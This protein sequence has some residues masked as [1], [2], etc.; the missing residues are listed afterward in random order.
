V[1]SERI[2]LMRYPRPDGAKCQ[3][4]RRGVKHSLHGAA[5]LALTMSVA[6]PA[7]RAQST[8][9]SAAAQALF[10]Q[11]R[12]LMAEGRHSEACPKLEES[13]RL[14]PGSG[15][16]LN[17]ARCYEQAG[18]LASAWIRYLEAASAAEATGNAARVREARQRA[19][20]VRPRLPQLV[21]TV[22]PED[23]ATAGLRVTRDDE[24]VGAAQWGSPIPIDPGE[25][26]IIASAPGRVRWQQVVKI[27]TEASTATV[28]IPALLPESAALAPAPSTATIEANT[29]GTSTS[30]GGTH[31][32]L[33]LVAGGVGVLGIGAGTFFGLKSKSSHDEAERYCDGPTCTDPRGVTAGEDAYSAG[34]ISTVAMTVGV[35]GIGAGLVLWFTAP[36]RS[37]AEVQLGVGAGRVQLRGAF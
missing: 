29:P 34:T 30:A 13:Q 26:T 14:D 5:L 23:H 24:D 4:I 27:S 9:Q 20:T 35:V 12:Q 25:H 16:L 17:L 15:T 18:L 36:P 1:I 21:I 10:E 11:A 22:A 7:A 32:T 6:A 19:E 3:E 33:A 2:E 31:R 8:S 28:T 37:T